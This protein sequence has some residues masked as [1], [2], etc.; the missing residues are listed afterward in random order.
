MKRVFSLVLIFSLLLGVFIVPNFAAEDNRVIIHYQRNDENYDGWNIWLWP[1]GGEGNAYD[2][3]YEDEFGKIAI[4]D[5][6]DID[7]EA[8][9]I[10]RLNDW[11]SKDIDSDRYVKLN[12][13]NEENVLEMFLVQSV[14]STYYSLEEVDLTPKFLRLEVIE[15]NV[16]YVSLRKP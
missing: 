10:I 1:K 8:G 3:S 14:E 13:I 7:D 16:I 15:N 5:L 4:I 6:A 11:E 2:F 12:K 9:F